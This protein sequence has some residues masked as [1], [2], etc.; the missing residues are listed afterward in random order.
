MAQLS[1]KEFEQS[2]R[3]LAE[4]IGLQRLVDKF[5][6]YHGLVTR[7][8]FKNPEALAGH[9]YTLS[10]G[11]R[12]QVPANLAFQAI[13][14]EYLAEKLGEEGAENL[15]KLADGVNACLDEREQIVA[16]K[17][18]DL[19]K[20]LLEYQTALAAAVGPELAGADMLMKA[21]PAIA[22]RLRNPPPIRGA[23]APAAE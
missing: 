4:A 15:E 14:A 18:G 21:V 6:R 5:F 8:G 22:E 20:A 7:R 19:D 23:A 12:R 17:E 13:W 10:A 1:Q 9:V 3:L 11:L 2:V 16:D